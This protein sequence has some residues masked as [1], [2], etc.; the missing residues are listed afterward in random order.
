VAPQLRP[1]DLVTLRVL[2]QRGQSNCRI[3]LTLGVSEAAIRYHLRR[4]DRPDARK[5]PHKVEHLAEAIDH[6]LRSQQP[7]LPGDELPRPGNL[8]ALHDWLC[9]EFAY[10]GSYKSVVRF[11]R[12]HYPKPRRRPYRRVETPPGAQAQVDWGTFSVNF[13]SRGGHS[14]HPGRPGESAAIF[15]WPAR[16]SASPAQQR[17]RSGPLFPCQVTAFNIDNR[18]PQL[19]SSSFSRFCLEIGL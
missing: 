6:W 13:H 12:A 19:S 1:E 9:Q 11:V 5:K 3:A 14:F 2:K 16:S 7:D 8:H 10:D 18:S 17:Y 4:A 15:I